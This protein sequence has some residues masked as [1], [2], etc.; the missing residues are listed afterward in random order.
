VWHAIENFLLQA[1]TAG[2]GHDAVIEIMIALL[3]VMMA[4]M[5]ILAALV[6]LLFAGLG[7]YGY[8]AIEERSVAAAEK[9]AAEVAEAKTEQAIAD[10]RA[11]EQGAALGASEPATGK[12]KAHGKSNASS[13]KKT[14]DSSLIARED[15]DNR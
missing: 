1:H 13:A 8:K 12:K 14:T 9:K 15:N 6:T 4:V 11:R 2:L 3:G 7:F 5:A 10:Y